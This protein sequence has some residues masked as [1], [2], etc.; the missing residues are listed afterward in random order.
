MISEET[1]ILLKLTRREAE[2]IKWLAQDM[3]N[4][5]IADAM[6]VTVFAVKLHFN[7]LYRKFGILK[8]PRRAKLLT[9]LSPYLIRDVPCGTKE[10]GLQLGR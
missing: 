1:R 7:A 9:L 3:S 6:F 4:K 2:T 8:H 5:E 10:I